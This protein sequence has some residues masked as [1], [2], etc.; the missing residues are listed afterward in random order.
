[1]KTDRRT[2]FGLKG[3]CLFGWMLVCL[4]VSVGHAAEWKRILDLRGRWRFEIGDNMRWADPR[5]YDRDW[6]FI[7]VPSS[8]EDEG[9]P[10]Y[11][12]FAWYRKRFR[13]PPHW[14]NKTLYLHLGF[15]DDVD[16]VYVNGRLIG[17]SGSFPPSYLSAYNLYRIYRI[18]PGLLR[19][20]DEEN[21]VAV[22]VF[23]KRLAG[24]LLKGKVGIYERRGLLQPDVDLEGIWQFHF[25]DNAA[26]REPEY[27][28]HRDWLK[29][30]V[31]GYWETQVD[32]NYDGIAWYRTWF[33][34]PAKLSR[35]KLVL[36][37]GKIDDLDE[38]YLNGERIGRTGRI[39]N[40]LTR[41]RI[42]GEEWLKFRAYEIP[43]DLLAT[44]RSNLLAVRVY[45]AMVNGGIYDGPVGIVTK[46][47]YEAWRENTDR[48]DSGK[49]SF[50]E[51]FKN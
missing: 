21:V 27:D 1:M 28:A 47:R 43:D 15:V 36:L 26:W 40:N 37:L 29:I 34:L 41:I 39:Y 50:W 19:Y 48:N 49:K 35:K 2:A 20:G 30:Y 16:E 25:G 14:L 46:E 33:E 8:W 11:N 51:F 17:F 18:P 6:G 3:I 4:H 42:G 13:L 23:D 38:V 32:R 45:D 22:R 7:F 10:G 5:F 12:G 44:D 24:G 31:P 9:Y